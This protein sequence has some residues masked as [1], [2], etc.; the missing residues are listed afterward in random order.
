MRVAEKL[1]YNNLYFLNGVLVPLMGIASS[2]TNNFLL[3]FTLFVGCPTVFGVGLM[4]IPLL[5]NV[6]YKFEKKGM[7]SG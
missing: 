7:V 1:G 4:M 3:F 6:L 5:K 2:Y